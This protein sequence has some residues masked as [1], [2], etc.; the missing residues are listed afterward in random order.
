MQSS[1]ARELPPKAPAAPLA[2]AFDAAEVDLLPPHSDQ[3]QTTRSRQQKSPPGWKERFQ[4]RESCVHPSRLVCA[5]R[6]ADLRAHAHPSPRCRQF[7]MRFPAGSLPTAEQFE[8]LA[9]YPYVTSEVG[10]N[11]VAYRP[12]AVRASSSSSSPA[13]PTRKAQQVPAMKRESP[14]SISRARAIGGRWLII[15]GG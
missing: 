8:E 5:D 2:A 6:E 14:G 11:T 3:Q 13:A 15:R 7:M 12:A 4:V 1:Q 10:S 9:W